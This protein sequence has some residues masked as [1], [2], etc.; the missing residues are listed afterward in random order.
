M[1]V[2]V[3]NGGLLTTIQDLGRKNYQRFGVPVAGAMDARAMVTGNLLLGNARD[4]ACLEVTLMGP[5]LR[6]DKP[7]VI[8]V[9]GGDLSPAVDNQPIEMYRA[10]AVKAGSVL[11]FGGVK[12]GCRAYIAFAGGIKA[13]PLMGSRSTYLKAGMGGLNGKKL[14]AE[15]VLPVESCSGLLGL[16]GRKIAPPEPPKGTVVTLR[17]LMGPQDDAFTNE[18]IRTF[19]SEEYTLTEQSDR[20]GC[21]LEGKKIAHKVGGDIITDGI[22]MGAVQVP[23]A[24][25]P[26]IM[27]A[28]RQ[29]T[30]GYA[31]IANVIT[32]DLPLIAQ[33]MPGNKVRFAE[34]SIEEAQALCAEEESF[35]KS[36]EKRFGLDAP[37]S[38]Q[39]KVNGKRYNVTLKEIIK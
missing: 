32:A 7:S 30:G 9:T 10:L 17:V 12:S 3:L 35:Y 21:R 22:S 39:V 27:L 6:F 36:L 8:A 16:S 4:D 23:T 37:V 38:L 1:S 25:L 14:A 18:G 19:L 34:T 28:D 13:P 5:R 29:T 24:G 33:E 15:D 26:I 2:T 31:K 20:M 11:S